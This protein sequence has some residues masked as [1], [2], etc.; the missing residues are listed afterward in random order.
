M[1]ALVDCN[2]FYVSCERVFQ[3]QYNGKPVIVLS[4]NDGCAVSRSN[5][6]KA[7]GIKMGTP[8][9]ELKEIIQQHNVKVFSSNYQLYGDLSNRV[10][11][12]LKTY[13]PEI[14]VYSVDEAFMRFDGFENYDLHSY[15]IE[16][17]KKLLK[18][19]GIPICIGF[20]PTKSLAKVA[21]KIAKKFPAKTLSSYVIDT[22]EKRIKALKWTKIEDVWGIGR[23]NAKKLK[24][25]G[26][27]TAYQFTQIEDNWVRRNMTI[28][29]LKL[30][31][32]L[33]GISTIDF[34]DIKDKQNIA[35][36]RSFEKMYN[37]IDDIAE[38]CSTFSAI[39][40][41]KL[42]LQKS[43]CNMLTLF[44]N[45]NYFRNDLEQHSQSYTI[46]T[47]FPTNSTLEIN[48]I[49]Q[50]GL[51]KIYK[52]GIYYK[53]A[54]VIVSAITPAD[55]YQFKIFGG[56]NP[57]HVDLMNTIDKLNKKTDGKILFGHNDLKRRHKMNRNNLSK[58]YSTKWEDILEIKL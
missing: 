47:D 53:K 33:S 21:N 17:Q 11:E 20:A 18:W 16:I 19:L 42:R 14:E 51:K 5:E 40:G 13:S 36:T 24:A 56:E 44:I 39:L 41:E 35:C 30:K 8:L 15:G 32:D 4:N 7:I 6:A 34:E 43:H 29:G 25:V 3:P 58:C 52:P 23:Q 26:I 12:I 31:H 1:Y 45:S 10:M 22:E 38:R 57:K 28:V 2:N 54:G 49:V 37:N 48:R 9:F 27:Y 46:K 55:S 50:V